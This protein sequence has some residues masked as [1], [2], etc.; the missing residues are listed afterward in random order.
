MNS[1]NIVTNELLQ[2][3]LNLIREVTNVSG[4][5][6]GK[7]PSAGTSAA[8]YAQDSHNATTSLYTI[9]SDM[10]IF[11]EKLAMKKCSIIQQFYEV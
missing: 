3:E 10:E 6:Q 5:L 1:V 4:A 8:R 9:L 7:T 11:T 2:I